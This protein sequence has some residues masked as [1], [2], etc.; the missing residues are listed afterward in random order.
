MYRFGAKWE[1]VWGP[2]SEPYKWKHLN[3]WKLVGGDNNLIYAEWTSW[4]SNTRLIQWNWGVESY[5]VWTPNKNSQ[6]DYLLLHNNNQL[7][8]VIFS[9]PMRKSKIDEIFDIVA[10][11][12]VQAYLADD[13]PANAAKF[14]GPFWP[15]SI[16]IECWWKTGR[17]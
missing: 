12:V 7:W 8:S 11:D 17:E 4:G 16:G 14:P 2:S 1:L 13:S 3:G 15:S 5:E 9:A 10:T 6:A